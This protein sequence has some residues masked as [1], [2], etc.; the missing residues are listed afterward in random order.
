MAKI[1]KIDQENAHFNRVE[2]YA[3]K[4]ERLYL[5]AIDEATR[6]NWKYDPSKPFSFDATPTTKTQAEKI[7][8]SLN[9]GVSSTIS[10][11]SKLEWNAAKEAKDEVAKKYLKGQFAEANKLLRSTRNA[12]ALSAFQQRKTNGLNLSDK[13]WRYSNQFKGDLEMALDIGIGDGRSA[14][15]LSR[16]IRTYLN[17]PDK[18][19]RRVRDK[20]GNLQ[21]SKN[22]QKYSPGAGL[23]R[24]SYKNAMRLTRTEINMAYRAS[25]YTQNQSLDFV[26]GF[27][28]VRS[29]HEFD[30]VVCN[31]LKGKYPKTFKFYGWHPQ[32][33]CH[34]EDILATED[35]FINQ[36]KKVLSGEKNPVIQSENEVTELPKGFTNWVDDNKDRIKAAK[37]NGTLPYFLRD[38][39]IE[40]LTQ[41][42][43]F[44]PAKTI[45]EAK[46]FANKNLNISISEKIELNLDVINEVNKLFLEDYSAYNYDNLKITSF[47]QLVN[48]QSEYASVQMF[49]GDLQMSF[50]KLFFNDM[51]KLQNALNKNEIRKYH[52]QGCNTI[53]SVIDHEFAHVLTQ[54]KLYGVGKDRIGK[55]INV[56]AE[57]EQIFNDYKTELKNYY[58]STRKASNT[59]I[60]YISE[61]ASTS[62][63]EFIAE[64]F[65]MAINSE[66]P[67]SYAI[68]VKKII[69]K[70][71]KV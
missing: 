25:D 53:K 49:K 37:E 15:E 32:C 27:E 26:V 28:V 44:T 52:P 20:H 60:D 50:N 8:N 67:S 62:L 14:A 35:E 6:L 2:A 17:D 13:V 48:V 4:V 1:F 68:K 71:Y 19:F 12:E 9:L 47:Y 11:A 41:K 10:E 31:S 61:Y 29:N 30:C 16:D 5:S 58:V 45:Q 64:S 21:L 69:D 43:I 59:S 65:T 54:K 7:I 22:A 46:D 42:Q 63:G 40:S 70:L 38:N 24:S 36:Q 51:P 39:K 55:N 18:L 66:N 34:V 33:R 57:F 23:Y 3:K 56:I